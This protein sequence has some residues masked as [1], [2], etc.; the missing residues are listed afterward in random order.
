MR[1]LTFKSCLGLPTETRAQGAAGGISRIL[2]GP[3]NR[4]ATIIHLGHASP[5]GSSDQPGTHNGTGLPGPLFGLAAGGA[6]QAGRSPGRWCALTDAF[7]PLPAR[8][9]GVRRCIFCGAFRDRGLSAAAP[10]SY[11]APWPVT[12]RTFLPPIGQSANRAAMVPPGPALCSCLG[13]E[14]ETHP[15]FICKRGGVEVGCCGA[16]ARPLHLANRVLVGR[17]GHNSD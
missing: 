8:Q 12:V 16:A 6:C 4:T 10:G 11:P 1:L 9:A 2:C 7:S 5:H 17:P 13:L 14:T 15:E 3:A